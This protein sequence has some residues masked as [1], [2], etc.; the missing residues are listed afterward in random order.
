M[1][2]IHTDEIIEN[3]Q[4]MCIEANLVLTKDVEERILYAKEHEES[5]IGKQILQ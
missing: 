1:R 3:I 5:S 2:V 4:A